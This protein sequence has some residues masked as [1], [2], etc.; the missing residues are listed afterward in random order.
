M[1]LPPRRRLRIFCLQSDSTT[2]FRFCLGATRS[3]LGWR[4]DSALPVRAR[5]VLED[6]A[7]VIEAERDGLAYSG[8]PDQ[9]VGLEAAVV[10]RVLPAAEL[11]DD[12]SHVGVLLN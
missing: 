2:D 8:T 1:I 7:V 5:Q 6:E 4:F 9:L 11:V 10:D 12:L 3:S